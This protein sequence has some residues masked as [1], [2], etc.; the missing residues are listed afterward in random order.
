MLL[1]DLKRW[2]AEA[3]SRWKN[4]RDR[5]RRYLAL[6]QETAYYY[7]RMMVLR[8]LIEFIAKG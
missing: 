1:D 7:G 3:E 5:K 2:A 6:E 8:E 4:L